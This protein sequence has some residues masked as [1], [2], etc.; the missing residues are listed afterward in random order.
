MGRRNH[1]DGSWLPVGS[2]GSRAI[3]TFVNEV[4]PKLHV[5]GHIHGQ[6]GVKRIGE[7]TF[8]N[9]AILDDAYKMVFEPE[10]FDYEG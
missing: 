9:A 2:L 6:H 10:V 4:K 5:F 3:R 7:T 8:I 1:L